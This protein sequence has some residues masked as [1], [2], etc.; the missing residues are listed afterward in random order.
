MLE[1][2][3]SAPALV[4]EAPNEPDEKEHGNDNDLPMP[5]EDFLAFMRGPGMAII[6]G[7]NMRAGLSDDDTVWVDS[8][9]NTIHAE[10]Q[11]GYQ[12]GPV[13]AIIPFDKESPATGYYKRS[14]LQEFLI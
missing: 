4:P 5:M 12:T 10:D 7:N 6:A 1:A 8:E 14:D 3:P 9:T 11:T 13:I 2:E